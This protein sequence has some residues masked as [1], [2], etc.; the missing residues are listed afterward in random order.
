MHSD[1]DIKQNAYNE[2]IYITAV[3][4]VMLSG[5]NHPDRYPLEHPTHPDW[6]TQQ[7]A[8]PNPSCN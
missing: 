6:N 8:S 3:Q 1:T 5:N 4:V 7:P 2:C